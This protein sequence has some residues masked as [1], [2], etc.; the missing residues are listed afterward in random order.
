VTEVDIGMPGRKRLGWTVV[1]PAA[2]CDCQVCPFFVDN[3]A[4]VEKL[5]SGTNTDCAYCGCTRAGGGCGQC[6]VRCGSRVDIEAWMGDVGGTLS[7][8]DIRL[9]AV[10]GLPRFIPQVDGHDLAGFDAGLAWPAYGIG[11][12]RVL[13]PDTLRIYPRFDGVDAHVA[14]GLGAGQLAVLVGYADDPL[15]EA[16]WTGRRRLIPAIAAQRWDVV[17]APNF[18]LFGNQPRAEHLLNFR[19][20]LLVAAEL[21]TEGIPAVPNLY[22]FRK[23]DLDRYLDWCEQASAAAVAS[24]LQTLRTDADWE[25]GLAGL[26]YLAQNLGESVRVIIT[27]ASRADRIATLVELFGSRLHLVSQNALQYARH[28]AL[29][30]P[31][32]RVDTPAR[33]AE[34]FAANVA[35]YAGLLDRS[36]GGAGGA[37]PG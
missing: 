32:G 35:Y 17:L 2:G 28:G 11:L 15:V 23:E 5:C 10:P 29:M 12:R 37:V 22:W 3:P 7:F 30:T 8:D 9:D 24:N 31:A 34:L 16:F 33:P 27:G 6:P 19:R 14:L 25:L 13:S 20:N 4:A 36:P 26:S 18:S 1:A 21:A